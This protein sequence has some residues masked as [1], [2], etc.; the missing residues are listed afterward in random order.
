LNIIKQL[1]LSIFVF[2]SLHSQEINLL[3]ENK[4]DYNIALD[5]KNTVRKDMNLSVYY[6]GHEDIIKKVLTDPKAQFAIITHDEL[7]YRRDVLKIENLEKNVKLIIPL[8]DK[9]I[10]IIVKRDNNISDILDLKAQRVNISIGKNSFNATSRMIQ[11]KYNIRWLET[12]YSDEKALKKLS[13]NELEAMII[14]EKK[15]SSFLKTIDKKIGHKLKFLSLKLDNNYR[16]TYIDSSDY[17]WYSEDI[18]TNIVNTI[19]ISYN[20]QKSDTIERFN[21]YV[22]NI[23]NLVSKISISMDNLRDKGFSYWKY[24]KP[25]NYR[26]VQWS[27]HSHAKKTFLKNMD[28]LSS[29]SNTF[30]MDF[31]SIPSGKGVIGNNNKLLPKDEQPQHKKQ[32]KSFYMM[33]TEVTQQNWED[34][35]KNNPSY[36]KNHRLKYY[37]KDNPVESI[38]YRDILNF[39][40]TLNRLENRSNYRL[41]T[42]FEWE[43]CATNDNNKLDK[44]AWY[45]QNSFAKTHR[46]AHKKPNNLGLYDMRGNVWEW[47]SSYYSNSYR[48]TNTTK[49]FRVLR[50]GSFL[51]LATNTRFS[52]RMKNVE[53]IKRFNNGF[54][55]VYDKR[56]KEKKYNTYKVKKGDTLS[57]ISQI[58]Y[59]DIK[60]WTLIYYANKSIIGKKP[61]NLRPYIKLKIPRIGYSTFSK[62]ANKG[63]TNKLSSN[64]I[65]FLSGTDFKPFLSP[66]LPKGGMA[67]DLVEEMFKTL[68]SDD[69]NITF[70]KDFSVHFSLLENQKF[71]VGVAWYK[72]DCSKSNLSQ[73]TK[74]RCK[75]VFSEPI[76]ETIS[77]L[78]K[79][80]SNKSIIQTSKDVH[81]S[82]I[83]RPKGVYIFDLEDKGLIDKKTITLVR[84]SSQKECFKLL[85]KKEVDFVATD[86]FSGT[87][88]IR[89]LKLEDSVKS[90][91]AISSLLEMNL[92]VH[93]SNPRATEIIGTLNRAILELKDSGKLEDIQTKHL[94]NFFDN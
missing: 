21:Y 4:I 6:S 19:L 53:N 89:D 55:L 92:I 54:R 82:K 30:G 42:E 65:K 33:T 35:M 63:F 16:T 84:A 88:M 83:C 23:K 48:D 22:E 85:V 15:P 27:L 11:R 41:P 45:S 29:F 31:V 1:I 43:Y 7:V 13:N 47:C 49:G 12:H 32:F 38:S 58:F 2:S 69:Y 86:N 5:I 50:G 93:S 8:Y 20:Y 57:L 66:I 87:S 74:R 59:Q 73:T 9:V 14:I 18:E 37:S 78:Y 39:I 68:N 56:V 26:K 46:V 17:S 72:P 25:Y 52:N 3:V 24:I 80:K 62:I 76:F 10:H 94:S 61:S 90:I 51:N 40:E 81:N 79:L 34:V 77:T 64:G 44:S 70:I 60:K 75:F 67:N 28:R 91:E 71:D 36:F